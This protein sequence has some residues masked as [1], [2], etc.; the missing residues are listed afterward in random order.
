MTPAHQAIYDTLDAALT[1]VK[2]KDNPR[3]QR[4][5]WDTAHSTGILGYQCSE[6][7]IGFKG[8]PFAEIG[9]LLREKHLTKGTK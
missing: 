4:V 3:L 7:L 8:S 1:K 9:Q 2:A 6:L 5:L